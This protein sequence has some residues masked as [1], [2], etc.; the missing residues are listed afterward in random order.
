MKRCFL[1]IA[2]LAGLFPGIFLPADAQNAELPLPPTGAVPE[3]LPNLNGVWMG[4]SILGEGAVR[5]A[6]G[7]EL[8]PFTPYGR[9]R[10]D[11]RD[12]ARDPTGFCQPSGPGRVLHSPMWYQI[13]QTEGQLTMLFEIYHQFHRIFTDGRTHPEPLDIT[14]WGSSIGRYEGSRLIVETVGLDERSWLFTAGINHSEQLRLTWVLEKTAPDTIHVT[15]TFEDPTFFS[16]PFSVTYDLER[17]P[18][19]IM[20]MI[21]SDN[22]RDA[23]FFV[24]GTGDV[25]HAPSQ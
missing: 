15:E 6:L 5:Q 3:G 22:N 8:P 13:I 24:T 14:W 20:E 10:W 25:T 1:T 18:Y 7:G 9:E 4:A 17:A 2:L 11:N 12:L 21:C 19:D 16:E 23:Q